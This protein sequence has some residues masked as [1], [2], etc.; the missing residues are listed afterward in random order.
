MKKIITIF[1]MLSSFFYTFLF[2]AYNSQQ[3]I[4]GTLTHIN[5]NNTLLFNFSRVPYHCKSYGIYTL[6]DFLATPNI[7]EDCKKGIN[8]YFDKN[9]KERYFPQYTFKVFQ[10]YHVSFK[11]RDCIISAQ[12]QRTYATLQLERGLAVLKPRFTNKLL[13]YK[14]KRSQDMAR[15]LKKGIWSNPKIMRCVTQANII[16]ETRGN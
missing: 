12:G 5:A 15:K 4:I 16:E 8:E 3:P 6:F 14:Y 2:G 7:T 10:Q 11:D 13:E 9:P 1:L